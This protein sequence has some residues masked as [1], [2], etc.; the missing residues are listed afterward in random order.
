MDTWYEIL[1][2]ASRDELAELLAAVE[3]EGH[4][5][6]LSDRDLKLAPRTLSDR[7]R[8]LLRRDCH[9]LVFAT[10]P[11]AR[12]LLKA[13]AARRDLTVALDS[14]RRIE[15]GR[16]A[17]AAQCYSEPSAAEI[18]AALAEA[19]EAGVAIERFEESEERHPEDKGVEMFTTAHDYVYRARGKVVGSP[20]GLL[21]MY[22]RLDE[23]DFV[24]VDRL[25]VSGPAV[26][27]AE[28]SA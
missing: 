13:I 16:F 22:R 4:G 23:L 26:P 8:D 19:A 11:Q 2:E 12:A 25:E 7:V 18:R 21:A 27:V 5:R 17:F 9:H 14:V 3:A 28:L 10:G 24:D 6:P 1:A 20:P 15:E